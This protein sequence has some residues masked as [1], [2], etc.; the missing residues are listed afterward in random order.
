MRQRTA[1]GQ[2]AEALMSSQGHR[3]SCFELHSQPLFDPKTAC[4][5]DA[6]CGGGFLRAPA[7][8]VFRFH[9]CGLCP[10]ATRP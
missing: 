10:A 8:R 5:S 7:A 3:F 1:F 6:R 9:L 2:L 4:L